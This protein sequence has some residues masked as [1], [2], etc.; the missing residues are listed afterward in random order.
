MRILIPI[1]VLS[2]I[3][4]GAET[5]TIDVTIKDS[6]SA[7]VKATLNAWRLK[8]LNPDE[9]LKYPNLLAL[10]QSILEETLNRIYKQQCAIDSSTCHKALKDRLAERQTAEDGIKTE[11]GTAVTVP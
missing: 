7:E 6:I 11:V 2:V 3:S 9:T 10:G 5:F 8:Q 1:L 4:L